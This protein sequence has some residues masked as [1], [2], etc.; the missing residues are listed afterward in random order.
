MSQLHSNIDWRAFYGQ[1]VVIINLVSRFTMFACNRHSRLKRYKNTIQEAP[2]PRRAQRVGRD[3]SAAFDTIDHNILITRLSCGVRQ[4]SVLGPLLFVLYTTPL[5]ILIS[6][7]SL[8][9][10]LYA[11]DTQLFFSF[12]PSDLESSITHLQNALQQISSWMTANLLT[13][14]SSKTEFLL[15]GLKQQL[16]KISSCSLDTA[17]SASNLG[18]IFDE[19]ISF[20]DQISTLSKSGPDRGGGVKHLIWTT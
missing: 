13:L 15:I 10:H 2:L 18:F 9:H 20:S 12:S 7:F 19:H 14:N 1:T 3:L 4:G 6:S 16:A 11:D 17:H 8:N 5:S